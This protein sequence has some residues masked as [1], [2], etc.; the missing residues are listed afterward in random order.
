MVDIIFNHHIELQTC[1]QKNVASPTSKLFFNFEQL[2]DL[3][4]E[5]S[6]FFSIKGAFIT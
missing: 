5:T 4:I 1:Q 2:N 6:T 3:E